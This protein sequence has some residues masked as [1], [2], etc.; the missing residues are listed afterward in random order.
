MELIEKVTEM[1]AWTR[2]QHAQGFLIGFVPTMGFLHEGH[3]SLMEY[4]RPRCDLLAASVFVNPTQFAPTED[5][6]EYPRDIDRDLELML[7]KGVDVVFNPSAAEIYPEGFQTYVEVTEVTRGLCGIDRPTFFRGVAT[8][9]IKLF[10]IVS[11]DLAVFGQKDFQQL[12]VIQRMA[13]DLHLDVEVIGRPTV[14]EPDG[15]AMSSRNVYLSPE[16]RKSAAA[17]NLSLKLAQ[18]M[19]DKGQTAA[20]EILDAVRKHIEDQPFTGIQ[21][22]ELVDTQDLKPVKEVSGETLLAMAVMVGKTRLIDNAVLNT[23]A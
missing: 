21:Y 15:L 6:D 18:E 2:K 1:K 16:E 9:V 10:N 22:V 20:S 7:G 4:A 17:L 23:D 13:K 19:V 11:P 14:R 5:L 3:L 8:V 12:V